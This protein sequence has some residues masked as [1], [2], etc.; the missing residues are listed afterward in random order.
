MSAMRFS[1]SYLQGLAQT[2]ECDFVHGDMKPENAL[3]TSN[4]IVKLT[5]FGTSASLSDGV[6][7]QK[8]CGIPGYAAP[9]WY[10][11]STSSRLTPSPVVRFSTSSFLGK[12]RSKAQPLNL[13]RAKPSMILSISGSL[14]A[15]SGSPHL[16]GV[17]D[18]LT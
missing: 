18:G 10:L 3:L 12:L 15:S 1:A 11:R 13:S 16:Q 7:M 8:R 9:V 2:H 5:D 4:S 6:A 14:C 17:N